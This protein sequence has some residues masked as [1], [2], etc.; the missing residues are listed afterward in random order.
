MD[1]RTPPYLWGDVW[2]KSVGLVMKGK[3]QVTAINDG[4][5]GRSPLAALARVQL[6][7]GMGPWGLKDQVRMGLPQDPP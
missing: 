2:L 7:S 1:H 5:K 3:G 4:G 6:V